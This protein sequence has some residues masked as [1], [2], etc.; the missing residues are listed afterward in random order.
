MEVLELR[1]EMESE[2][3]MLAGVKASRLEAE[4]V[5][6]VVG[7]WAGVVVVETVVEEQ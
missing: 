3:R 7:C 4:V 2:R 5:V 1:L 6:V